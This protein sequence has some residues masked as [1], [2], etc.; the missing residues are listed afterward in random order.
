MTVTQRHPAL[1]I[2]MALLA[3]GC[4]GPTTVETE[5][6]HT[7][8]ARLDAFNSEM[9]YRQAI[10]EYE[11]GAYDRVAKK[12]ERLL[13]VQPDSVPCHLLIARV[14]LARGDLDQAEVELL[15]VLTLDT[16]H[17]EG[18]FLLGDLYRRWGRTEDALHAYQSAHDFRP[19]YMPCLLAVAE[20]LS[21]SGRHRD[22]IELLESQLAYFEHAPI[23][24]HRL[25]QV[26]RLMG[27]VAA[28]VEAFQAASRVRPGD[29]SLLVT[30]AR[31]EFE[32]GYHEECLKTLTRLSLLP[33]WKSDVNLLY[34]QARCHGALRRDQDAFR[35]Y[36]EL[37]CLDPDAIA[38]WV[39]FGAL[40]WKLDDVDRLAMCGSRLRALVSDRWEGHLMHALALQRKGKQEEAAEAFSVAVQLAPDQ[41]LPL[42]MWGQFCQST[43]ASDDAEVLYRHVLAMEPSHPAAQTCLDLLYRTV[44][45]EFVELPV[46]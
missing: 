25:G 2:C 41:P 20:G 39:E 1:I 40:A 15:R 17:A 6:R 36:V 3:G 27:D 8:H 4:A 42:I 34:M 18:W 46:P 37:A 35:T 12:L 43:G 45:Q 5:L 32:A 29:I 30:L 16:Q 11:A 24:Y 13:A 14:S 22:A 31:T 9:L 38:C 7:A 21:V 10:C 26:Y 33:G 19:G 44:R 23:L 28:A